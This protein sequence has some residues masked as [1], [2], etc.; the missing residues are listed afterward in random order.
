MNNKQAAKISKKSLFK[1]TLF[2]RH[3]GFLVKAT[4]SGTCFSKTRKAKYNHPTTEWTKTKKK[5]PNGIDSAAE[6]MLCK[7]SSIVQKVAYKA[8]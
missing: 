2:E 8:K 3:S 6:K 5:I 4:S 7:M 1:N